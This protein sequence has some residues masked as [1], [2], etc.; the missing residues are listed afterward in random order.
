MTTTMKMPSF[1]SAMKSFFGLRPGTGNGDFLKEMK[2]LTQKDRD[3]FSAELSKAGI[4][5]VAPVAKQEAPTAA[6]A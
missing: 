4:E 5:H 3:Y 6:A 2:D 1:S